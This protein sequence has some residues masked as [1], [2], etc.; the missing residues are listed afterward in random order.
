MQYERCFCRCCAVVTGRFYGVNER[1]KGG[2][3]FKLIFRSIGLDLETHHIK[4]QTVCSWTGDAICRTALFGALLV[5]TLVFNETV[6]ILLSGSSSVGS[7][8]LNR[9]HSPPKIQYLL[10]APCTTS[11]SPFNRLHYLTQ[12]IA[13]RGVGVSL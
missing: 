1:E 10:A 3:T 13:L 8:A 7:P 12:V 9:S 4:Q 5:L 11:P 2:S 6:T